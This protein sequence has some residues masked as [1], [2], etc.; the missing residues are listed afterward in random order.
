MRSQNL[1]T[2]SSK[3]TARSLRVP[4]LMK[5]TARTMKGCSHEKPNFNATRSPIPHAPSAALSQS[6]FLELRP[7]RRAQARSWSFGSPGSH[8][9]TKVVAEVGQLFGPP[10]PESS[11][12][13]VWTAISCQ[14]ITRSTATVHN[15]HR[16]VSWAHCRL[17]R[18]RVSHSGV[19][20]VNSLTK[21]V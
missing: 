15:C 14:W 2:P 11:W 19:I 13:A 12:T 6:S 1:P 5:Q 21:H 9:P 7:L 17:G 3:Q 20:R 10:N 16:H 18:P 4:T 8:E